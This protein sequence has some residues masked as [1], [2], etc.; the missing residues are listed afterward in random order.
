M[1]MH[2]NSFQAGGKQKLVKHS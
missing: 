1:S 2:Q